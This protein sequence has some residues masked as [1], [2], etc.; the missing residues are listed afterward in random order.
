M[1]AG[2]D[3]KIILRV[4]SWDSNVP[5]SMLSKTPIGNQ[6]LQALKVPYTSFV[7]MREQTRERLESACQIQIGTQWTTK[8]GSH[9]EI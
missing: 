3:A 2:Q 5:V 4:L 6:E 8:I 1:L 7:E 9:E